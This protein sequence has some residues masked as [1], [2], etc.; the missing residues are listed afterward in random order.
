MH[1]FW[2]PVRAITTYIW[3][4]TKIKEKFEN[5]DRFLSFSR[6]CYEKNLF[7]Y[8]KHFLV[9][10]PHIIISVYSPF[11]T[12]LSFC[13]KH[14]LHHYLWPKYC[15]C[16][17]VSLLCIIKNLR[18]KSAGD[19]LRLHDTS[20]RSVW[21]SNHLC[22][23]KSTMRCSS[24]AKVLLNHRKEGFCEFWSEK[25]FKPHAPEAERNTSKAG[26]FEN[27]YTCSK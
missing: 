13:S 8:S 9:V 23:H 14:I 18:W 17:T 5:T 20:T 3:N 27:Y 2:E 4:Q 10:P 12:P 19:V 24:K 11:S 21:S 16:T 6:N 25:M 15:S 26:V 22:V 7:L 1:P